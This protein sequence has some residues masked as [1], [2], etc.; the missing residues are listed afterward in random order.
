MNNKTNYALVGFF[1]I[2]GFMVM[3]F[4]ALWLVKPTE[5]VQMKKYV[6]YFD[7]SVLGLNI[8]APVKYRGISVGKVLKLSINKKNTNQIRVLIRIQKDTPISKKTAAKLT[9]QG[10]T[11]LTYI[12]LIENDKMDF[13]VQKYP[14]DEQYPVI[15][16]VPSLFESIQNSIG[17][18]YTK[19][20]KS[21][22]KI[23]ALLDTKN[24]KGFHR[25]LLESGDLFQKLNHLLDENTQKHIQNVVKHLDHITQQLDQ[26]LP[27]VKTLVEN[28]VSWENN[29][30]A[31][32]NS[33]T[34]SYLNIDKSIDGISKSMKKG[35][36][37]LDE[38][39]NMMIP[40][41]N[42]S[43]IN[44]NRVLLELQTFVQKY[45][46]TPRDIF[47]KESKPKLAPGEK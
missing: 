27:E 22:D 5:D 29:F 32:V 38:I 4:F 37:N 2:L 45:E 19:V 35:E 14:K 12:N 41:I 1:V 26:T 33:I 10:I 18:V 9:S 15:Q 16:S 43:L 34:K 47:V 20:S 30:T 8:D 11:G 42:K 28:S 21:L 24:Q 36:G 44:L 7:E 40:A 46:N 3:V 13:P 39:T 25:L 31:S 23:D 17:S 6:I